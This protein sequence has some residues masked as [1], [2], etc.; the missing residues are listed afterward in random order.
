MI[1]LVDRLS[2]PVWPAYLEDAHAHW[3]VLI[4]DTADETELDEMVDRFHKTFFP[5]M[6]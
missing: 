5:D 3:S 2:H 1:N 4:E 6:P